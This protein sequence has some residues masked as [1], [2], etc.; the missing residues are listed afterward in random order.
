MSD[1]HT[2]AGDLGRPSWS[3][4]SDPS[5]NSVLIGLATA[6]VL[7][8]LTRW[9]VARPW[10]METDELGFLEQIRDHWFPMHHTLFMTSGRIL[11]SLDGQPV[12]RI[13]RSRHADE[14]RWHCCTPGGG[15]APLVP[16]SVAAAGALVLY[17]APVFWGYGA[18]AGNYTAIVAVGC[19]LLGVAWRS[20]SRPAAW[21]PFAAAG[22]LALGTGYRQDIGTFWLPVLLVILW[23]HRWRPAFLAG[24]VFAALN[25]AWL[26][27]MLHEVGGWSRYRAGSAEFAYQAGYLNSVWSL[28][29]VDATVRYGVKLGFALVWTLG[30]CLLFVPRGAFRVRQMEH[31]GFLIAVL[32]LSMLPAL[33]SHLLRPFRR[34]RL[35]VPLRAG[36]AGTGRGGDRDA[37]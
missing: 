19:F 9:P 4:P 22:V 24:L 23:R 31:G 12:P 10:A 36:P 33:A 16:P 26:L 11:G 25:L 37:E 13:P 6:L 1:S 17:V 15:C 21:H 14:R 5:F 27:P 29:V 28:G 2:P 20:R 7:V 3:R 34:S 32:A 30:P 18:M 35:C 8:F